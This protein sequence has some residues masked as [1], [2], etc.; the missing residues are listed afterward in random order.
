MGVGLLLVEHDMALVQQTCEQV[1]VLDFGEMIFEG[2]AQEMLASEVVRT[3]YLGRK[4]QGDESELTEAGAA[5]VA[6]ANQS[7]L[8]P[9]GGG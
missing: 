7:Q 6:P 4:I 9:D 5:G 8:V 2:T 3:A 1:Y